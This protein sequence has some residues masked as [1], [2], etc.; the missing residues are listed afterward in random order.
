MRT[1]IA[2]KFRNFASIVCEGA[3]AALWLFMGLWAVRLLIRLARMVPAR[4]SA[5]APP[6]N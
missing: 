5:Q 6:G 1:Q 2:L 4:P 3:G